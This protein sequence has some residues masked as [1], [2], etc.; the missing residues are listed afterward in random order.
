MTSPARSSLLLE[1][2]VEVLQGRKA[3][4]A[5][6][7]FSIDA[8]PISIEKSAV[9][10]LKSFPS[11]SPRDVD[12]LIVEDNEMNQL[13]FSQ[14]LKDEGYSFTIACNGSEGVSMYEKVDPKVILMDVSMPVMNGHDATRAIRK[15]EEGTHR[16]I[17]IIGATAH[18]ISGD[19]EQ[20]FDAGMD[21]YL[22][23]PVSPKE[24][25]RKLDKWI[26]R[27]PLSKTA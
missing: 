22:S 7:Q 3:E 15:I 27:I 14:I 2:L 10:E 13:L 25:A 8:Q 12:V 16:R 21:D 23:K 11:K 5:V 1:T 19:M 18:A 6:Q 4:D 26:A 17:P 9:N 20:C 24:L